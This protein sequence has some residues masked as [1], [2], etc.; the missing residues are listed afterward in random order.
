[1]LLGVDGRGAHGSAF[2]LQ[3]DFREPKVENLGVSA[4]G[5]ED[6]RRLYVTMDDALGMCRV[7][8]IGDLDGER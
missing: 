1:M 5:D 4:F 7:E 8:C 6:V 2:W 3:N